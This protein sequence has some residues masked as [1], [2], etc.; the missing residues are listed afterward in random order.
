[1]NDA[2]PWWVLA[3]KFSFRVLLLCSL[4]CSPSE[5]S[6]CV[7]LLSRRVIPGNLA[8]VWSMLQ[9]LLLRFFLLFFRFSSLQDMAYHIPP[10]FQKM[11]P[12]LMTALGESEYAVMHSCRHSWF[13][14]LFC[15]IYCYIIVRIPVLGA[16]VYNSRRLDR[17]L[18]RWVEVLSTILHLA[19]Q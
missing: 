8:S 18:F 9:V 3:L 16:F 7:L 11:V 17:N 13:L 5:F 2:P 1:M 14:S 10:L 12:I 4:L 19:F 6:F 15:S